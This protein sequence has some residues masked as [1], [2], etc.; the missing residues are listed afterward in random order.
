MESTSPK[1]AEGIANNIRRGKTKGF[2]GGKYETAVD[3]LKIYVRFLGNDE[4][5]D[6]TAPTSRVR[7]DEDGP[8]RGEIRSW[9]RDNGFQVA[10]RGAIPREV[11][12][13]YYAAHP[14][15]A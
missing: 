10:V 9:A 12:D 4:G 15:L 2:E 13:A 6:G 3:E 1:S 7:D 5:E 8:S 11:L 14:D